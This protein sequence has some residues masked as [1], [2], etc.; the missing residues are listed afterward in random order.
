[1]AFNP[2]MM[3]FSAAVQMMGRNQ[4]AAAEKGR[5]N[6][7]ERQ[8]FEEQKRARL[9]ALQDHNARL[10]AYAE[11]QES[12]LLA[13]SG[14]QDRSIAAIQEKAREQQVSALDAARIRTLGEQAALSMKGD[15]ARAD[16]SAAGSGGFFDNLGTMAS[17]GLRLKEVTGS[18][19]KK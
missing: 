1:M 10:E 16:R 2:G 6:A 11:Y 14:R 3:I 19:D 17:L 8:T 13:S 7:I 4:Q 18:I 15:V 5:A 12:V 9:G